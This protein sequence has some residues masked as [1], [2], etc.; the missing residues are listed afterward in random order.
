MPSGFVDD[1]EGDFAD[2]KVDDGGF[3]YDILAADA[4]GIDVLLLNVGQHHTSAV[5]D[6]LCRSIDD[7]GIGCVPESL[8]YV[9]SERIL[10]VVRKG[11]IALCDGDGVHGTTVQQ[12]LPLPGLGV[13]DSHGD[14]LSPCLSLLLQVNFYV[15]QANDISVG[16][17]R[18]DPTRNDS[19]V[20]HPC[21]FPLT[22][23]E[24]FIELLQ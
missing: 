10:A 21:R 18:T 24:H 4:D 13:E 20:Q 14:L 7:K 5:T 23:M 8:F 19:V 17:G 3:G 12:H 1:P 22:D 2:E 15:L 11:D 6:D 16:C 9:R